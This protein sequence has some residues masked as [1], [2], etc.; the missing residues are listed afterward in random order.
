MQH[1]G[2]NGCG[3]VRH[4]QEG[5]PGQV[6]L[7]AGRGLSERLAG[8]TMRLNQ[9]RSNSMS[10][11]PLI[12]II[13]PT[14]NNLPYLKLLE[15]SLHRHS[16]SECPYELIVHVNDGS[17][18]TLQWI[19]RQ[20]YKYSH[21]AKNIGICR[22]VNQAASQATG[23][24]LVYFNDDM[25][26]LPNWDSHLLR[27]AEVFADERFVL[28]ATMI[29]P[30]SP[31]NPCVVSCDL[32]RSPESWDEPTALSRLSS[33]IR[34]DWMGSTWPPTWVPLW[35]WHEV[36]GYSTELSPGMGS[37]NDF[38]MK[39]YHAGCR[40]FIGVGDSLVYHFGCVSTGKIKK[41]NGRKQFLRKW[42]FSQREFDRQIL[43]RGESVPVYGPR[44]ENHDINPSSWH[45]ELKIRLK[46]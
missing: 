6:F 24:Y 31:R 30:N 13:V 45:A 32:G 19:Q 14:W 10:T 9:Q 21:S 38:S 16:V 22:A 39:L 36:G 25:V 23:R 20:G 2:K 1:S 26:A 44:L 33:L 35:M 37:D 4:Y 11:P 34:R 8:H 3:A 41:N 42:G 28:S 29:E 27:R 17:D 15:Q 7:P 12:S 40:I 5:V 18:G 43:K 46:P